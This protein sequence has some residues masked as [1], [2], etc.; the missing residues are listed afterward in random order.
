VNVKTTHYKEKQK[1]TETTSVTL[2]FIHTTSTFRAVDDD[3]DDGAQ[4]QEAPETNFGTRGNKKGQTLNSLNVCW[5]KGS[6]QTIVY[7]SA[8]QTF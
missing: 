8:S 5:G 3:E 2:L 4:E 1:D 7:T 6:M